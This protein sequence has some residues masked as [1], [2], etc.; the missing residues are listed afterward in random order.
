[1]IAGIV[2]LRPVARPRAW[3]AASPG[4]GA[5]AP[6]LLAARRL[7]DNPSAGFRAISGIVIA[8][9]VGTVFSGIAASILSRNDMHGPPEPGARRR[10]RAAPRGDSCR[11]GPPTTRAGPST[12]PAADLGRLVGRPRG[13]PRRPGRGRRCTPCPTTCATPWPAR[14]TGIQ[15][16][17]TLASCADTVGAG[18]RPTATA[19]RCL[20]RRLRGLGPRA[21][22][23]IPRPSTS[24]GCRSPRSPRSPTGGPT[25]MEQ[26]R[27]VLEARP[28]RARGRS[29]GPTWRP[30][31]RRRCA[32]RSGSPTWRWR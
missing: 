14:P 9:F 13:P 12:I 22:L 8:V 11:P 15:P 3:P 1:M 21:P 27:T 23:S 28:A 4:R 26:A 18:L 25:T 19:R 10:G 5:R 31:R 20:R 29:P 17:D 32:P 24:T 2:R 16:T 30:A 7:E 6:S